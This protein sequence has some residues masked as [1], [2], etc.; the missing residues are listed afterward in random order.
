MSNSSRT[1][2]AARERVVRQSLRLGMVAGWN[3][4]LLLQLLRV[5]WEI[6]LI[7]DCWGSVGTVIMSRT[8]SRG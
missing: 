4:L 8:A 3:I 2:A 5:D 1:V 7:A 6:D